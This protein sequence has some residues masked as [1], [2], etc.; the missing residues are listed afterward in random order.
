M[1]TSKN[2]KKVVLCANSSWYLYNFR[3]NTIKAFINRGY[4]VYTVAPHDKKTKNLSKIC[5]KHYVFD[6]K[7]TGMNPFREALVIFKLFWIYFD[8]RPE[9]VMNFTPKM[10][11][12][13]TIAASMF[14]TKVIN[15]ISGLGTIFSRVSFFSKF[16]EMLY[17]F[18]QLFAT[19]IFFQNESDL[20]M[21]IS[22][23]IVQDYKSEYIPGSGVNLDAF[24]VVQA[25]D[26]GIVRFIIVC[27]LL[28][29][30]GIDK[31]ATA[32][33]YCRN[34]YGNKVEFRAIGFLDANNPNAVSQEIISKWEKEKILTYGGA[35]DDVRAEISIADCVVLPSIYPE[36]T[37]KSLLEAGAMGKPIITTKMPGCSST[38]INGITGFLCE[39]GSTD[40]LIFHLEKIILMSHSDRYQMGLKSRK[41][42]EN[43]FDERIVINKYLDCL[44]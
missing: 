42:M 22:K 9:F 44:H 32:A 3:K 35:L 37:P 17:R 7:P 36:G 27:R 30:K 1:N 28:Y 13:S 14:N 6:L 39:P 15:N 4:Q 20:N 11:I 41:L 8:I 21:F 18:S 40:D 12:Y 26:D 10:N 33:R 2:K 24:S 29:E 43:K 31:F 23:K 19:K 16:V 25:P 34:K 5:T 38:V